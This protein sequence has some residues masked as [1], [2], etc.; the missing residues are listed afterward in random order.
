MKKVISIFYAACILTVFS[1]DKVKNPIVPT[2]TVV[3]TSF[4]SNDNFNVSDSKKTLLE[5]FTGMR[6][7]NCPRAARTA[8]A[9]ASQYPEKLIVI[10]AHVGDLSI[11]NSEYK[12]D[13]RTNCGTTW[14]DSYGIISYPSGVINKKGYAS[15]GEVVGDSKWNEVVA[16]AVNDPFVVKLKVKTNY[17]TTV[18]ALNVD[19]TAIF[20]QSYSKATKIIVVIIEDGLKGLQLDGSTKIEDYDFEHVVRGTMNGDWGTDLTTSTK[21][22]NDSVA[23]SFKN[24]DLKNG[25]KYTIPNLDPTKAPT[26]KPILVNDKNVS[27]VVY[28]YDAETKHV[29]Q[30][31]KVK[32]R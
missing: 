24:F 30:V 28:A 2:N 9:L 22:A 12:T 17:D 21:N 18:G 19:V 16:L 23:V 26:I 4:V 32:I 1:C 3:G 6:C 7:Q 8:T 29:L 27:V 11:P 10:A 25:L 5:D 14:K 20:K 15:N 31:E 13:F